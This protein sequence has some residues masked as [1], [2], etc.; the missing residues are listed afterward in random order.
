MHLQSQHCEEYD[1]SQN[2]VD[3]LSRHVPPCPGPREVWTRGVGRHT[4]GAGRLPVSLS[5]TQVET[6]S[7]GPHVRTSPRIAL[8]YVILRDRKSLNL[9][10]GKTHL[11]SSLNLTLCFVVVKSRPRAVLGCP[12][13]AHLHRTSLG[14]CRRW[15]RV[16]FRHS[17]E[18][19]AVEQENPLCTSSCTSLDLWCYNKGLLPMSVFRSVFLIAPEVS[20]VDSVQWS[21]WEQVTERFGNK[22]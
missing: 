12:Q 17:I 3:S 14:V 9:R 11:L 19:E 13:P 21:P 4:M 2:Q 10:Q 7:L 16:A 20:K 6:H 1:C 5:M 15:K 8:F 18:A 22:H